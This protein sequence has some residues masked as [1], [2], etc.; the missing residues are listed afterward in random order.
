MYCIVTSRLW[1]DV[2]FVLDNGIS[3]KCLSFLT[4][5]VSGLTYTKG[6]SIFAD[7]VLVYEEEYDKNNGMF[8][9]VLLLTE[10]VLQGFR[11]D[12][13]LHCSW[14]FL[15]NMNDNSRRNDTLCF[16]WNHHFIKQ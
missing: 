1:N 4:E 15:T 14:E 8:C 6:K 2:R 16:E 13:W 10:I 5:L 9:S 12:K 3:S 7:D 11:N